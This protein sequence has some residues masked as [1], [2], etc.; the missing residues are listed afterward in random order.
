MKIFSLFLA[1]VVFG[2]CIALI[3]V[4]EVCSPQFAMLITRVWVWSAI[5]WALLVM[6]LAVK[7]F[8]YGR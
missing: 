4:E 6:A 5:G 3:V 2:G 1:F 8:K 7:T